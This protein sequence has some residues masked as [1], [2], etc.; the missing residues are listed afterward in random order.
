MRTYLMNGPY[1]KEN[2]GNYY[3]YEQLCPFRDPK[4]EQNNQ[5]NSEPFPLRTLKTDQTWNIFEKRM[6]FER[7][8]PKDACTG[9]GPYIYDVH[10]GRQGG[11]QV[12]TL[13][14]RMIDDGG[15]NYK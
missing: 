14:F 10:K 12:V 9:R 6:N 13:K 1:S 3:I 15:L 11:G 8:Q 2:C 4:N 5:A 7:Q